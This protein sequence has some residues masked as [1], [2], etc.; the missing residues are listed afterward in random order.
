MTRPIV[1]CSAE[2]LWGVGLGSAVKA[3]SSMDCDGIFIPTDGAFFPSRLGKEDIYTITRAKNKRIIVGTPER[4]VNISSQ[5]PYVSEASKRAVMEVASFSKMIE[6]DILVVD[7]GSTYID[8]YAAFIEI[9]RLI[10]KINQEGLK[11]CLKVGHLVNS[12]DDL[13]YFGDID[14]AVE[15][16]GPW[17]SFKRIAVL[18][19]QE[20]I[21]DRTLKELKDRNFTGYLVV[22]PKTFK[23]DYSGLKRFLPKLMY[24]I[25]STWG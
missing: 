11:T 2:F 1:M 5:N 12:E 3:L 19:F 21:D 25:Y 24:K 22:R 10:E 20:E 7:P 17:R 13:R 23:Y 8:K 14:V 15:L 6:S 18:M 16:S 9:R 4:D